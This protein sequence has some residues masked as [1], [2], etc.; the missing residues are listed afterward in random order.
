MLKRIHGDP[1]KRK[2]ELYNLQDQE[3]WTKFIDKFLSRISYSKW[4]M[5][6]QLPLASG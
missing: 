3:S 1:T 6:L 5:V 2:M 4:L